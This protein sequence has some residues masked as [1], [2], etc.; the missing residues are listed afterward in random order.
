MGMTTWRKELTEAFEETGDTWQG[1]V[2][3]TLTEED[4]DREFDCG[5]GGSEG[6]HFTLWTNDRV[7]FPGVYEGAEWVAWVPRHP[8]D[9]KTGH[10]GGE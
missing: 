4:L 7:Y 6:C 9:I 1:I 3:S 5:Y 2:G 10:V 8:C